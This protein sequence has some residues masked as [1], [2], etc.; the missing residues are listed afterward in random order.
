MNAAAAVQSWSHWPTSLAWFIL[1]TIWSW[2]FRLDQ[3]PQHCLLI[4]IG[5]LLKTYCD[6]SR[7]L[8][9]S[10]ELSGSFSGS[11]EVGKAARHVGNIKIS[12]LSGYL[13]SKVAETLLHVQVAYLPGVGGCGEEKGGSDEENPGSANQI[14]FHVGSVDEVERAKT[15]L[16]WHYFSTHGRTCSLRQQLTEML[17]STAK[18]EGSL[19]NRTLIW[20]MQDREG[21]R[22]P[23]NENADSSE[24]WSSDEPLEALEYAVLQS[25]KKYEQERHAI[26]WKNHTGRLVFSV[27]RRPTLQDVWTVGSAE[28][29]IRDLVDDGLGTQPLREMRLPIRHAGEYDPTGDLNVWN[30]C[31]QILPLKVKPLLT[32]DSVFCSPDPDSDRPAG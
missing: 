17:S 28:V 25:T 20:K 10:Q 2:Y 7:G 22:F 19:Q 18:T 27:R 15:S 6:R 23:L 30:T 3:L 24:H 31:T 9:Y 11:H 5:F 16:C 26:P 14:M 13:P 32:I 29:F 12:V 4:S 1:L 8:V 21:R